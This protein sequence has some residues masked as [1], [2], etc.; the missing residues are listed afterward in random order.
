MRQQRF[1]A[2]HGRSTKVWLAAISNSNVLS[3][4][5]QHKLAYHASQKALTSSYQAE[6]MKKINRMHVITRSQRLLCQQH[7]AITQLLPYAVKLLDSAQAAAKQ[8]IWWPF[9]QHSTVLKDNVTVIDSRFGESFAVYK[10]SSDNDPAKLQAQYDACASWWTQ[11]TQ[12]L[13]VSVFGLSV[14]MFAVLKDSVPEIDSS[15]P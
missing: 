13:T 4:S 3:L 1:Y 14:P 11:V 7:L 12:R 5:H 8:T 15:E 2:K 9:T 6:V 10:P